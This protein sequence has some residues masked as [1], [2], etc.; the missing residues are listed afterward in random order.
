MRLR[1]LHQLIHYLG[2]QHTYL[3][4]DAAKTPV[5]TSRDGTVSWETVIQIRASRKVASKQKGL[6]PFQRHT[7]NLHLLSFFHNALFCYCPTR[8]ESHSLGSC[9]LRW[10]ERHSREPGTQASRSRPDLRDP[11]R[12]RHYHRPRRQPGPGP[13]QAGNVQLHTHGPSTLQSSFRS[14][15]CWVAC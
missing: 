5:T 11:A 12:G 2:H 8:I 9:E 14:S 7:I 1:T 4:R 15:F 3:F 10:P 13:R 6:L